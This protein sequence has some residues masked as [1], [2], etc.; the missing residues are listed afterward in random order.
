MKNEGVEWG[1][2]L[3]AAV[4]GLLLTAA[5]PKPGVDFLAW[6]ALV[7][8]MAA[9][10]SRGPA[11]AFRIGFVCGLVHYLTLLYWVV[12]TMQTYGHLPVYLAVPILFLF[13]AFLALY[14]AV[15][16]VG[17]ARLSRRPNL[18]WLAVPF[19]WTALELMRTGRDAAPFGVEDELAGLMAQED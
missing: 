1:R 14:V 7:P 13:S 15:F 17:V 3:A 16:A 12:G 2:L 18:V 5:F 8:L 10:S 6:A 4:S 11:S 9:V 19:F